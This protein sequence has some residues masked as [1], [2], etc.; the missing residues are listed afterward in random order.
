MAVQPDAKYTP[1]E[2]A[3]ALSA[4]G[5]GAGVGYIGAP[6]FRCAAALWDKQTFGTSQ[7][8]FTLP[9][10]PE[11]SYDETMCPRTQDL[12]NRMITLP[13]SEFFDERD[14]EAMAHAIRK[15]AHGLSTPKR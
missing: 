9:G 11:I 8:P 3:T 4:E 13:M 6:I 15:V 12:L 5:L 14:I 7:L 2:F 10:V 1:Q